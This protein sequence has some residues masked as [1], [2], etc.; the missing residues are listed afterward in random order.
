MLG[1]I[2]YFSLFESQILVITHSFSREREKKRKKLVPLVQ[3]DAFGI[4]KLASMNI[5]VCK[6]DNGFKA[7]LKSN[8]RL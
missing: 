6:Q 3:I 4:C 7:I 8:L 1:E 5:Y 2:T